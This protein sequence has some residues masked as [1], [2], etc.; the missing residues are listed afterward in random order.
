MKTTTGRKSRA[1]THNGNGHASANDST[2]GLLVQ[3][4]ADR[5]H[6]AADA[7][8]EQAKDGID[9]AQRAMSSMQIDSAWRHFQPMIAGAAGFVRQYPMRAAMVAALLAS[10]FFVTRTPDTTH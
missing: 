4:A 7:L 1:S 5:A 2:S 6:D 3:F 8:Y 10:A 9:R